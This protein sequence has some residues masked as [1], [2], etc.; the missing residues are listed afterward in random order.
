VLLLGRHIAHGHLVAGLA[1][2]LRA[3]ALTA[4]AVALEARK[5][6]QTEEESTTVPAPR[7]SHPTG[8]RFQSPPPRRRTDDCVNEGL[9]HRSAWSPF[10]STASMN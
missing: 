5:A 2:A 7:A 1:T 3:G 8:I 6:A 10:R 4:D 9:P